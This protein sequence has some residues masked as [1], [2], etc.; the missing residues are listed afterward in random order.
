M[1][2][3]FEQDGVVYKRMPAGGHGGGITGAVTA[4]AS[5]VEAA[6]FHASQPK[7]RHHALDGVE[8][9]AAELETAVVEAEKDDADAG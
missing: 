1:D 4:K 2:D 3:F 5:D 8:K 9:A 7:H 6:L